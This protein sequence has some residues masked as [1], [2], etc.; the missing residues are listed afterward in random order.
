MVFGVFVLLQELLR[1][2][3]ER[4]GAPGWLVQQADEIFLLA[5]VCY[6]VCAGLVGGVFRRWRTFETGVALFFALAV[7]SSLANRVPLGIWTPQAFLYAKGLIVLALASRL[8]LSGQIVRSYGRLFLIVGVLILALGVVDMVAPTWL[9]SITGNVPGFQ[10]GRAGFVSAKSVFKVPGVMAWFMCFL[11]LFCW[12]AFF[13]RRRWAPLLAALLFAAGCMVTMRAAAIVSLGVSVVAG[14]SLL[15]PE[16]RRVPMVVV[17]GLLLIAGLLAG[18]TLARLY[19]FKVTEY[20]V[21]GRTYPHPRVLLYGAGLEIAQH[22][23]PLGAGMGR[24]GSWMSRVHYSPLYDEYDLSHVRGLSREHPF[25]T[26]DTFWPMVLGETG[27]LGALLWI[28]MLAVL[29]WRLARHVGASDD[30]RCR[31]FQL[32]AF[33]ILVA[34]IVQS[35]AVPVYMA[36][37]EC[38]FIFGAVGLALSRRW[39]EA[40]T[41]RQVDLSPAGD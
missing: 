7:A 33:M 11:S 39:T 14:I 22:E 10:A 18:P 36:P 27:F 38:Y 9:R 17:G 35:L 21:R 15:V 26:T 32:G 37:P 1:F 34:S 8:S 16:R 41:H 40:P 4:L 28:A 6:F 3:A 12:A 20:V 2:Q 25:Y 29:S 24:Y 19:Q 31:A 30:R 13:V 23:F 5:W